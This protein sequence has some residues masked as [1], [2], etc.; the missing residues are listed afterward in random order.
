MGAEPNDKEG[1]WMEGR[2]HSSKANHQPPPY[3]HEL[4]AGSE[5]LPYR[6]GGQESNDKTLFNGVHLQTDWN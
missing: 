3:N 5:G 4:T 1:A 6:S 2:R